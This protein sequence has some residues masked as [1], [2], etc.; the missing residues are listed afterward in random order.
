MKTVAIIAPDFAP[1]NHPPALRVRFFAS[2]LAEFGWRPIIITTKPAS[3]EW[4]IDQE[5]LQLLPPS[6]EVIRTE[7]FSPKFTR[8]FGI[9]DLGLR[10]MGQ[11]WRAL[12]QLCRRERVDALFIPV[13]PNYTML[14]GR[15]AHARLGLPYVVDYID[16]WVSD[17]YRTVPRERRLP[18][19]GASAWLARRLEPIALR[20]AAQITGVSLGTTDS[21]V[22]R[23]RWLGREQAT[24]IPYGGEPADFDYARAHPRS[25]NSWGTDGLLHFGYIGAYTVAMAPVLRAL[26]AAVKL[27][28]DRRPDFFGKL[29]LHFVGTNYGGSKPLVLPWAR[30]A[31]IED[32]VEERPQRVAYLEALQLL[33]RCHALV[34]VGS[35]EAHYT[36]SK[37]FPYILARRPVLA[38]LHAESSATAILRQTRACDPIVFRSSPE[39]EGKAAEILAALEKLMVLPHDFAPPTRWEDFEPYTTRAMTGRLAAVLDRAIG[40]EAA[41]TI[42]VQATKSQQEGGPACP[43]AAH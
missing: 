5:N 17:Y 9:G 12:K 30:Q 26:F 21:V 43:S 29:R 34:I 23:Y 41:D 20:R 8:I 15:L 11:H 13:P 14:L 37:V 24:E 6:L 38:I 36:A 7:A 1:S 10:T 39:L 22:S 28:R 25:E 33:T 35:E 3:Y 40:I 32:M 2:H 19:V 27:G 42:G 31:G 18:K 16:P 4:T